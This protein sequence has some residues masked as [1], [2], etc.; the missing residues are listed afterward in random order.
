MIRHNLLF[1]VPLFNFTNVNFC[2]FVV[3]LEISVKI[4]PFAW[5]AR[6]LLFYFYLLI[7]FSLQR[8]GECVIAV[9]QPGAECGLFVSSSFSVG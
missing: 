4:F 9:E 5:V 2:D 8:G 1:Q 7:F 6:T 3:K